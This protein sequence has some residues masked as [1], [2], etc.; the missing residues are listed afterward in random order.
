MKTANNSDEK[1]AA[2]GKRWTRMALML[3]FD[4]LFCKRGSAGVVLQ[5]SYFSSNISNNSIDVHLSNTG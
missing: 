1:E 3:A 2:A 4:P 5:I